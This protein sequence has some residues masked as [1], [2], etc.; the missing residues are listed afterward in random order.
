M[1]EN[2]IK[3]DVVCYGIKLGEDTFGNDIYLV[4]AEYDDINNELIITDTSKS[5]VDPDLTVYL[6]TEE[7]DEILQKIKYNPYNEKPKMVKIS[8]FASAEEVY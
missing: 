6:T 4:D 7:A 1:L 8:V 3:I 2:D 5:I